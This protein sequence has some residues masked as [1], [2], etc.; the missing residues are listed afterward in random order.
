MNYILSTL[1]RTSSRATAAKDFIALGFNIDPR[2][3]RY[4]DLPCLNTKTTAINQEERDAIIQNRLMDLISRISSGL[5]TEIN[6]RSYENRHN[7]V[8][9]AIQIQ[10]DLLKFKL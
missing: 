8:E 7:R 9:V 1:N 10:E 6:L 2:D 4:D 3:I 5:N